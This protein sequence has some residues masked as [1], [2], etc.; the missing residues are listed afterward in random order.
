LSGV[1]EFAALSD[2]TCARERR[3]YL[4]LDRVAAAVIEMKM[5]IDDQIDFAGI[6]ARTFQGID[7]RVAVR[8]GVNGAQLRIPLRAMSGF[9]DDV[10]AMRPHQ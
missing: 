5:R 2:V 10:F 3:D 4:V 1:F 7:Q 9:D 8:H 6:S